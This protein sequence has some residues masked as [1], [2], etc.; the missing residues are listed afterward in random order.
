MDTIFSFFTENNG[1]NWDLFT[2]EGYQY[3]ASKQLIKTESLIL[4]EDNGGFILGAK[5]DFS[6][7]GFGKIQTSLLTYIYDGDEY[8]WSKSD[9]IYDGSNRLY[10]IEY[11]DFDFFTGSLVKSSR[12][13]FEYNNGGDLSIQL[14]S[15]WNGIVWVDEYRDEYEYNPISLSEVAFP[16][17]IALLSEEDGYDELKYGK[18]IDQINSYENVS[19]GT[20]AI[21]EKS[22]EE[23]KHTDITSFYYSSVTSTNSD[24]L[25]NA[26]LKFYPNPAS[27]EVTF[28]WKGNGTPLVLE[29]YQITGVK[30]L[31]QMAWSGREISVSHLVNGIY[32][33]KLMQGEQILYSGKIVKR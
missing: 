22:A 13:W 3:N 26:D 28:N 2:K 23:W 7:T 6:Y 18:A 10:S 5:T 4:D 25:A 31:E 9:Y 30:V 17:F 11:S 20:N 32:F 12:D 24:D 15:S 14:Y 21:T 19:A 8:P 33:F 1:A 27:K 29:M 16:V